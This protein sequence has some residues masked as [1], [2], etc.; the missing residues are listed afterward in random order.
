LYRNRVHPS[1][2]SPFDTGE[3]C[4]TVTTRHNYYSV[5]QVG[6]EPILCF[7]AKPTRLSNKHIIC[8]VSQDTPLPRNDEECRLL[9]D[10]EARQ[11]EAV[12][13]L[14]SIIKSASQLAV[15]GISATDGCVHATGPQA[16]RNSA[17][18]ALIVKGCAAKEWRPPMRRSKRFSR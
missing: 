17:F 9:T 1:P 5:S 15:S 8:L 10:F 16:P 6:N 11:C 2:V 7:S 3:D 18:S 14:Q 4:A 12:C 13:P